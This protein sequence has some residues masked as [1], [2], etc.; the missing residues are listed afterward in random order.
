MKRIIQVLFIVGLWIVSFCWVSLQQPV[1]ASS[2]VAAWVKMEPNLLVSSRNVVDDKLT[3]EY[4]QKLDLNNSNV[5]AFREYSGLYPNLARIIVNHAP[6]ETVEEVLQIPGLTERQKEI[7]QA[8]LDKFTVTPA[9][10][11]LVEGGDRYNPGLYK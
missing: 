1:F 5:R 6:Y 3:T 7:L 11:A 9:E 4:G 10:P 2:Q 8:N